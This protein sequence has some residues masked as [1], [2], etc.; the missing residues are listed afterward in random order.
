MTFI[1]PCLTM[2]EIGGVI[3]PLPNTFV[4]DQAA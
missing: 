4:T 3:V 1:L 2:S